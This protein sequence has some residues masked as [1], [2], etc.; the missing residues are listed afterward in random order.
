MRH[1]FL[2]RLIVVSI[3]ISV[4]GCSFFNEKNLSFAEI[5][6]GIKLGYSLKKV[7]SHDKGAEKTDENCAVNRELGSQLWGYAENE[8]SVTIAYDMGESGSL[9]CVTEYITIN[10]NSIL[11]WDT[12]FFDEIC[13][14]LTDKYGEPSDSSDPSNITWK[15]N[16]NME[17]TVIRLDIEHIIIVFGVAV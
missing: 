16:L 5:P 3:I 6:Y 4:A 7:L 8:F 12:S 1:R 11:T 14:Q 13:N 10:D 17:I 9:I 15:T 2:L